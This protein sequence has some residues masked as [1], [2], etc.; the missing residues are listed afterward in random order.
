M[1]KCLLADEWRPDR[2]VSPARGSEMAPALAAGQPGCLMRF[3][4]LDSN[5][6]VRPSV[7]L[8]CWATRWP[9]RPARAGGDA[10]GASGGRLVGYAADMGTEDSGE[11]GAVGRRT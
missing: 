10:V 7:R 1:L 8:R 2:A 5:P 9:T 11:C 6:A 4:G 3:R